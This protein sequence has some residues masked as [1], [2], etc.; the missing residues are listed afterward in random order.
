[1]K[2]FFTVTAALL[3]LSACRGT[4]SSEPPVHLN[5]NMDTQDKLKAYRSSDLFADG[6]AMRPM[7]PGTVARGFE[8]AD[9]H[10]WRGQDERGEWMEMLPSC[11]K[12]ETTDCVDVNVGFLERGQ[13]RYDIFCGPCHDAAGYDKGS[14]VLRE[15]G[16][17]PVPSYHDTTRPR[18][19]LGQLFHII[20]YGERNPARG[21]KA[22][23]AMTMPGYAAQIPAD[24][25]WAIAAYVRAL[26][27]SQNAKPADFPAAHQGKL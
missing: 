9:D 2:R 24:D 17:P 25:R 14:V 10:F 23:E 16:L 26:Q 18:I 11:E 19:A 1:M 8:R 6:R 21:D 12:G 22:A 27:R 3:A 5:P 15:A 13:Q 7:V 20:S 4:P